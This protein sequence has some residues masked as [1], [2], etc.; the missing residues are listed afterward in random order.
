M[1]TLEA[2]ICVSWALGGQEFGGALQI[3]AVLDS[4]TTHQKTQNPVRQRFGA[5]LVR[6]GEPAGDL[7]QL[8]RSH[9]TNLNCV[10]QIATA[11]K[12]LD[13]Q[14]YLESEFILQAVEQFRQ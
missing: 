4:R 14:R 9:V 13:L 6:A 2:E 12:I 3:G 7:I 5:L 1:L 8:L 10:S 11:F